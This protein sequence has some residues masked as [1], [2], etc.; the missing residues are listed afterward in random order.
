MVY[1]PINEPSFMANPVGC[2]SCIY[3]VV[4]NSNNGVKMESKI[5]LTY[6]RSR[7]VITTLFVMSCSNCNVVFTLASVIRAS[8][9]DVAGRPLLV[10]PCVGIHVMR[11]CAGELL[12]RNTCPANFIRLVR[13]VWDILFS[14]P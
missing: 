1:F 6:L 11:V 10:T 4:K 9:Y 7:H 3:T 2:L 12:S 13:I 5:L 8:G 14:L